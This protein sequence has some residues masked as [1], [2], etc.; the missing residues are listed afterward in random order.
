MPGC[1][2]ILGHSGSRDIKKLKTL[3]ILLVLIFI[4]GCAAGHKTIEIPV[5]V[6]CPEPTIPPFPHLA[7][8]DITED[9]APDFIARSY[10]ITIY[11][12]ISDDKF[13][14]MQLEAYKS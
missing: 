6:K 14:R 2:K 3:L 10:V 9:S 1:N 5:P 11:Q 7:I 13:L 4:S 12:L 8:A